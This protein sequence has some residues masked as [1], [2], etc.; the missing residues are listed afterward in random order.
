MPKTGGCRHRAFSHS[1]CKKSLISIKQSAAREKIVILQ[2]QANA[3]ICTY[4]HLVDVTYNGKTQVNT[5]LYACELIMVKLWYNL[6]SSKQTMTFCAGNQPHF[7]WLADNRKNNDS[8]PRGRSDEKL[9]KVLEKTLAQFMVEQKLVTRSFPQMNEHADIKTD[10]SVQMIATFS[11][12]VTS[13]A[14]KFCFIVGHISML[15]CN[16]QCILVLKCWVNFAP[17]RRKPCIPR[18]GENSS[19]YSMP[20]K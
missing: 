17:E 4:R 5:N 1:R 7:L 11:F 19:P 10:Q 8:L 15:F 3:R 12:R 6:L 20:I 16:Y 2:A 14:K 13:N 9:L 18:A